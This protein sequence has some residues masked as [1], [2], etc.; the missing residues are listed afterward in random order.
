VRLGPPK[1]FILSLKKKFNIPYFIETGTFQGKTALWA[2]QH[3]HEVYTIE[4][5]KTMF[6]KT[7]R[8]LKEKSNIHY[9]LGDSRQQLPIILKKL[10]LPAIIWLD[11]HWSGGITFGEEDECPL[12]E[13]IEALKNSRNP[14][15]IFIDDARMFTA[16]PPKPHNP[17][18]WPDIR[19]VLSKL[20]EI[21]ENSYTIIFEDV[22]ID[23][24]LKTKQIII[25][26]C[27]EIYEQSNRKKI[28]HPQFIKRSLSKIIT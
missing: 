7:K 28:F 3:F 23:S 27:Q 16:P 11:A 25:D 2:S 9:L 5:S 12:I 10:R 1:K 18:Y 26:Y 20:G 15:Y 22:I 4:C 21:R 6:E 24:P 14:N 17:K 13:E 8:V 19:T